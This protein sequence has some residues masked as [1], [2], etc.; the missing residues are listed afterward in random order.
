MTIIATDFERHAV[1]EKHE[2]LHPVNF[3]PVKQEPVQIQAEPVVEEI[4]EIKEDIES[5]PLHM[6]IEAKK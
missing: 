6:E 4:V 5:L 2:E 3:E 1:Q